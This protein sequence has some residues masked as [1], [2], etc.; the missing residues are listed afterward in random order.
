MGRIDTELCAWQLSRGSQSD[1]RFQYER[2]ILPF[3]YRDGPL[4][5]DLDH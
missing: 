1:S 4:R 3:D 2:P 5:A